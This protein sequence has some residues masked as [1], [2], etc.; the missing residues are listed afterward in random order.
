MKLL[1]YFFSVG[2][3]V[4]AITVGLL[5]GFGVG[6][7]SRWEYGVVCGA[8]AAEIGRAHV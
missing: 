3:R 7:L 8:G 5:T 2:N 1:D 4:T 6:I